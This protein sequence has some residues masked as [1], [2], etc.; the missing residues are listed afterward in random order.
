MVLL[1]AG[2]VTG[3]VGGVVGGGVGGVASGVAVG[4]AGV[5][6]QSCTLL[7]SVVGGVLFVTVLVQ[8]VINLLFILSS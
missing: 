4:V 7:M 5:L 6:C 8:G 1:V 3:V 2:G